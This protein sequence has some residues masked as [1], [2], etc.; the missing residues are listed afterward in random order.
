M[1]RTT[2]RLQ[3]NRRNRFD[4]HGRFFSLGLES[5]SG[6][7]TTIDTWHLPPW[8]QRSAVRIGRQRP[9]A[10]PWCNTSHPASR[11]VFKNV[12]FHNRINRAAFLAK[13]TEDAFGQIDVVTGCPPRAIRTLLRLDRDRHCRAHRFTELAGNAALF[14][15]FI[16][17]QGMQTPKTRGQRR[18][19]FRVFQRD[20]ASKGVLPGQAMPLDSSFSKKLDRKSFKEKPDGL[21]ETTALVVGLDISDSI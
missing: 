7:A 17:A 12:R 2:A 3:R 18:L 9:A 14:P 6:L 13:A 11:L 8:Q 16:T 21:G 1:R 10:C 4:V 19:L 5:R 20:L 15:V